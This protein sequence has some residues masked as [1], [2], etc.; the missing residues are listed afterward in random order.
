[1][2]LYTSSH[3]GGQLRNQVPQVTCTCDYSLL[4]GPSGSL[5]GSPS[6]EEGR[7]Q[8]GTVGLCGTLENSL[9]NSP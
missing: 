7:G 8:H 1:M 5:Q 3:W 4:V 2:S 6:A 9:G